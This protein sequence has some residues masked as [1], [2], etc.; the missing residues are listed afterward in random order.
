MLDAPG[1]AR[2]ISSLP[3]FERERRLVNHYFDTPA[4]DLHARGAMLRVRE[5]GPTLTACLKRGLAIDRGAFDATELEEDLD[6]AEWEHVLRAGGDLAVLDRA[7]VR[8]ALA[9]TGAT[10]L[11]HAGTLPVHRRTFGVIPGATLE[12]DRVVL[13]DGTVEHELELELGSAPLALARAALEE[14]LARHG[15]AWVEQTR[16]KYERFLA[17]ASGGASWSRR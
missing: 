9:L 6:Q 12:L 15:V 14:L 10:S 4:R 8:E 13:A 17:H 16:T 2:L 3:G 5:E 7:P 11:P 1:Y